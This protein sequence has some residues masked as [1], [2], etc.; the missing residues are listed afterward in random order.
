MSSCNTFDSFWFLCGLLARSIR[1]DCCLTCLDIATI[2]SPRRTTCP[3]HAQRLSFIIA[4][5][6]RRVIP[7]IANECGYETENEN[8]NRTSNDR[9]SVP[10]VN[11]IQ[12]KKENNLIAPKR[13]QNRKQ[14]QNKKS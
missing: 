10:S 14:K 11:N 3:K 2:R 9:Q 6:F 7:H 5:L 13:N 4:I 12:N 1:V 8:E